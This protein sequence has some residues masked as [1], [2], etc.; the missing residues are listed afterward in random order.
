MPLTRSA[1]DTQGP[2][3]HYRFL[4]RVAPAA[5]T[6]FL[7][8]EERLR[9][10]ARGYPGF[11][12]ESLPLPLGQA[13]NGEL[14]YESALTFA[15]LADFLGWMDSP[16]RR[17][18]LNPAERGGYRY[19]GAGDWDGY[20]RWLGEAGRQRVPVWKVNLLVL[21]VLYPT[22]ELL[23]V[24]LR[25]L[26]LDGPSGLLLANV[27]S[28]ALTGWWLVPG[29]SRLCGPWLEGT[30]SRRGQRLTLT[31]I[32]VGLALMLQLFRAMPATRG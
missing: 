21:L 24:L 13:D 3:F 22:V 23:R 30:G 2:P 26:P 28:V 27:C 5:R 29:V 7:E 4:H 10:A 8:L 16:E 15:T 17:S 31:A 6:G 20:A 14:L 11:V 12:A 1:P 25:P 18:L 9:T 19:A 32:L